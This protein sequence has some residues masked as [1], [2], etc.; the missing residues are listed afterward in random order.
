MSLAFVIST[1]I[2]FA[3]VL[4]IKNINELHENKVQP[5]G[6][7]FHGK[8][9]LMELESTGSISKGESRTSKL[10]RLSSS[11][12]IDY[13]SLVIFMV[14]YAVFNIAYFAHFMNIH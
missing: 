13:I 6:P 8:S 7:L 3:I 10:K 9:G 2:E 5:M 4:C 11:Q 14:F 12:K 1:M